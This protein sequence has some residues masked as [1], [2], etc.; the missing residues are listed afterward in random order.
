MNLKGVKPEIVEV[1]KPKFMLSGRSGV[2]KTM[3]ALDFPKPYYID[4]EGGAVRQQYRKK[5]ADTGGA[6]FGKEQGSQDFNTV[7][8]EIKSL[9]TTKHNFK[10]LVIDSFSHLYNTAAAIAEEKIGNDFGRD[11]KEANRPTRQL[12]RWLETIDMTVILICHAKEKWERR[13]RDIVN[14]GTS[15]DG[16]DKLEFSL[17]LWLEANK[18][19][20]TRSL[21][22][23]KSRIESFPEGLE[24]PLDYKEFSRLYGKE[25]VE[26]DAAPVVMA[27]PE[28]VSRLKELLEVVK[29][30]ADVVATWLKRA[31]ADDF[32]DMQGAHISACITLCENK[33][34]AAKERK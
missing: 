34:N 8:E 29:I 18:L 21:L 19:G 3:L 33:M 7:I 15:F 5:L 9:A 24:I 28:Q 20:N 14:T 31:Q 10:T 11:K 17:D 1:P 25:T 23:K 6:Y 32:K 22:V 4:T 30:D 27:T 13:G 12:M 2:G 16:Y 26:R